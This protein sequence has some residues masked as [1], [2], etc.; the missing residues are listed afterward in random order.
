MKTETPNNPSFCHPQNTLTLLTL[1]GL[2]G[3]QM[4]QNMFVSF[5][6]CGE[7][8]ETARMEGRVCIGI[9]REIYSDEE[10]SAAFKAAEDLMSSN[11]DIQC[12]YSEYDCLMRIRL[13]LP[14]AGAHTFEST[15]MG[16]IDKMDSVRSDF[17]YRM[18]Q[19]LF[20]MAAP[21]FENILH[22]R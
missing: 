19:H 6:F 4:Q 11:P 5:R 18:Q 17:E 7:V 10:Y 12:F 14:C 2:D 21:V 20:K 9:T 16:G 22:K 15:L 13:W 3:L 8:Y 1:M